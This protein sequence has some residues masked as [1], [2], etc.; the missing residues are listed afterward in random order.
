[1]VRKTIGPISIF[2]AA[3]KVVPS[4]SIAT[5]K[6]G[7]EPADEDAGHDADQDPEVQLTV[8]G[9]LAGRGDG[10]VGMSVHDSYLVV[11]SGDQIDGGRRSRMD[12][13]GPGTGP[14]KRLLLPG[15]VRPAVRS[16][17][18]RVGVRRAAGSSA[19]RR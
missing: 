17:P 12:E 16:G 3:T 4:G 2:M 7:G 1:M 9:L 6:L 13:R 15:R 8:E 19:G 14:S 5:A 10:C 18:T 11:E